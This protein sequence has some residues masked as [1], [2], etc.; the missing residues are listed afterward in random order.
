MRCYLPMTI[1]VVLHVSLQ[2]QP[3]D[4]ADFVAFLSAP[5][6][7]SVMQRVWVWRALISKD[8]ATLVAVA[9]SLALG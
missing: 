3:R 5:S 2:R 4:S 6:R 9:K 7:S 8:C 1:E